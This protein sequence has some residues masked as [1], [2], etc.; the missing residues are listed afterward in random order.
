MTDILAF[1]ARTAERLAGYYPFS[2]E[3]IDTV[4]EHA[5]YQAWASEEDHENYLTNMGARLPRFG[6]GQAVLD[7]QP[8]EYDPAVAMVVNLPM[9]NALDP[10]QQFQIAT[11]AGTNPNTRVIAFANPSGFRYG[12]NSISLA[13]LGSTA[14]GD[15]TAAT[16]VKERYLNE[17]GISHVNEVGYSYGADLSVA[18]AASDRYGIHRLV[19]IEP[20]SVKR[21]TFRELGAD[22][23]STEEALEHY[24]A[25]NDL[26]GF[27]D[28]RG[29]S[30]G[31]TAL[32]YAFTRPSTVA[33]AIGIAKGRFA[34]HL[35]RALQPELHARDS[36]LIV[37]LA[38]GSQSELADDAIMQTMAAEQ[39]VNAIRLES[40]K[41][42]LANDLHLHAAII[43]EG[44]RAKPPAAN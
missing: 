43:L 17:Q 39:K 41:H 32:A 7:I 36:G 44:L 9:A 21:R 2:Q 12:A 29:F 16:E 11:I 10:N 22:F 19:A 37:A 6:E 30:M 26:P 1:E 23:A 5:A 8:D 14:E 34:E 3:V 40:Q 33:T 13:D 35:E 42:A 38:W 18:S 4:A 24:V 25:A 27:V 31:K 28:A 20:A 15:F